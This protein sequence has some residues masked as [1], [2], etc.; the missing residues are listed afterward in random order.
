M[1]T[2][3]SLAATESS[4]GCPRITSSDTAADFTTLLKIIYLPGFVNPP[5][6]HKVLPLTPFY[7]QIP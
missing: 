7:P 2:Q 1:F 6:H 5:E 4:N 3:A